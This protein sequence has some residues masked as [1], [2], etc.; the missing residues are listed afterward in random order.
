MEKIG[1]NSD[2][3]CVKRICSRIINNEI[4]SEYNWHG[5][6]GKKPLR[7]SLLAKGTIGE[8]KKFSCNCI[9]N[10]FDRPL[11]KNCNVVLFVL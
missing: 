7:E 9:L 4:A 5:L 2:Y 1:G 11:Q 8:L 6:K 10:R 3:E